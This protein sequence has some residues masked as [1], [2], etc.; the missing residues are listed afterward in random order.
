[1]TEY[2]AY[3]RL[4]DDPSSDRY[5]AIKK[6]R[7][8]D[9]D[10]ERLMLTYQQLKNDEELSDVGRSERAWQAYDNKAQDIEAKRVAAREELQRSARSSQKLSVPLPENAKHEPTDANEAMLDHQIADQL[11]RILERMSNKG[12][13]LAPK[14]ANFLREKYGDALQA[15]GVNAASQARAVLILAQEHGVPISSVVDTYRQDRHREHQARAERE[16][17]W[18]N[19]IPSAPPK[20][21]FAMPEDRAPGTL[22]EII[23][24]S[25]ARRASSNRPS[26]ALTGRSGSPLTGGGKRNKRR[27]WK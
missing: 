18:A 2:G 8:A 16:A 12:G 6:W 4:R 10:S 19:M 1:M 13:P 11:R 24:R 21:P 15:T 3:E 14:P 23:Q 20:P 26:T 27:L 22:A 25:K 9:A 7:A 5:G 17:T